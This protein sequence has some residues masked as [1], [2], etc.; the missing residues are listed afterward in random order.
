MAERTIY[1]ATPEEAARIDAISAAVE[2]EKPEII[3]RLTRMDAAE[4]DTGVRG[5]LRRAIRDSM[6][7]P[8]RLSIET[9]IAQDLLMDFQEG[10]A[11][12]PLSD[13]E[14]IAAR[15]G[16]T[17]ILSPIPASTASLISAASSD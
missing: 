8:R 11:E 3:A 15:L 16:M 13:M 6:I 17:L 12:L 10:L 9:E 5:E 1:Q 2:A 7:G 14:R 4:R